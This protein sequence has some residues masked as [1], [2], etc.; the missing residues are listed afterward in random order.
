[1]LLHDDEYRVL[2]PWPSRLIHTASSRHRDVDRG[3]LLVPS[4]RNRSESPALTLPFVRLRAKRDC[5]LPPLVV[6]AGGPGAPAI[7]AFEENFFNH[8]ERLSDICD[9]VTFDQRGC[10]QALPDLANP[11]PPSY[12]LASP[13]DRDGF[14]AAHRENASRLATYYAEA[15]V[16]LNDFN[17]IESA[18]DVDDLRK[19]LDTEIINLHGASYGSHLGLTV[20]REHGDHVSR[21]ILCIVEGLNDTH[22]LP[23]N[24]DRHFRHITDLAREDPALG[25]EF[26]DLY[27]ELATVLEDFEQ[28]PEWIEIPESDQAAPIGK[29]ALQLMLGSSLGSVHAIKGLPTLVRQL[30]E[31]DLRDSSK[32]LARWLTAPGLHAMMLAM[33][34]AS[35]ATPERMRRIETERRHALLDDSFNLPF[36]YVG[37]VLGVE[38]L[39]D[40]FRKPVTTG[41]PTLFCAGTLDGRTPI[42]NAEAVRKGFT[43]S[44]LVI[45]EGASHQVPDILIEPEIR[46]LR[47][48]DIEAE[49]LTVPFSFD[50]PPKAPN[51]P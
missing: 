30:A 12:D 18:H 9:V 11:W 7:G 46:F 15:S 42:S 28:K 1:M 26:S 20:L 21:T 17:T 8:A 33:D 50:S 38:D 48:K 34:F 31:R 41:T 47:D 27:A 5:G 35:G 13:L 51:D 24:T 19:A 39:G 49:R 43:E 4:N 37:D 10:Q 32:R 44:Q 22:K 14:L 6:L 23:S 29:F 36:P 25:G 3:T 2:G 40:D 16:D 45:V